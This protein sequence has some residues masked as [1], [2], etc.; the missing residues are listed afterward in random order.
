MRHVA[1]LF[2]ASAGVVFAL[3]LPAMI[4]PAIAAEAPG[5][6]ATFDLSAMPDGQFD[7]GWS[8]PADEGET[9]CRTALAG[10]PAVVRVKAWW[11]DGDLRPAEGETFTVEVKYKDTLAKPAQFLAH[12]GVGWR[13]GRTPLH[14]FGGA[15]DGQ[16]KTANVPL[17]WDL[18]AR[19]VSTLDPG[20]NAPEMDTSPVCN[21]L[22]G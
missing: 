22:Y 4:P 11:K 20:R 7:K 10:K 12:G 3:G 14:R 17:P 8:A 5:P 1:M 13:S 15:N 16:W 21:G 6:V 19:L 2:S 18:V 9:K